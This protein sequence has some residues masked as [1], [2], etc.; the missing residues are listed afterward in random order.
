MCGEM[1]AILVAVAADIFFDGRHLEFPMDVIVRHII[2]CI[3]DYA[4]GL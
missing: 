2:R 3:D 4:Q 1:S